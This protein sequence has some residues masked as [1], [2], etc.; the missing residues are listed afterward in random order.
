MG[1]VEEL[2]PD[3]YKIIILEKNAA[4]LI[5]YETLKLLV[6]ALSENA[7]SVYIYMLNRYIANGEKSFQFTLDQVKKYIGISTATRSNNDTITNIL[8]VLQKIGLIEYNMSTLQ[9]EHDSFQNIKT[10]YEL[11]TITNQIGSKK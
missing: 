8:C 11:K 3:I 7:I 10:I 6:D 9:Q 1:L 2:T 4:S 5:P